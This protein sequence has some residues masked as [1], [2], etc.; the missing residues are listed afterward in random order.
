[1]LLRVWDTGEKTVNAAYIKEALAMSL[2][3]F[4]LK[5]H[6]SVFRSRTGFCFGTTHRVHIS[7]S[8]QESL[9]AKGPKKYLTHPSQ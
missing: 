1:L 2:A 4:E 5:R 9:V 7:T 3:N 6:G 8:V